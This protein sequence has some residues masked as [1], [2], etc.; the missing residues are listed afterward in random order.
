M[1]HV[2]PS[3]VRPPPPEAHGQPTPAP[4]TAVTFD[5]GGSAFAADVR[6]V[7]EI[8][9]PLPIAALPNAPR[10]IIGLIDLRQQS[11]PIYDLAARLGLMGADNTRER[12]IVF[13]LP[14]NRGSTHLV[15]VLAD[16]VR[17]VAEIETVEV[18]P[19]PPS[20]ADQMGTAVEGIVRL[21]G[22][23]VILIDPARI[24]NLDAGEGDIFDG[25]C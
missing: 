11:I 18:E 22:T 7:R 9:G 23:I 5:L 10:D 8:L 20:V 25:L 15:G 21:D 4:T 3:D 2:H 12:I 24:F 14:D 13:E 6:L 19:L 16:R 17:R 1:E